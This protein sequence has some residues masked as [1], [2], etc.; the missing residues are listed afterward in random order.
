MQAI[1]FSV[2]NNPE[3]EKFIDRLG[4]FLSASFA[5]KRNENISK[6]DRTFKLIQ[7]ESWN[8]H[9]TYNTSSNYGATELR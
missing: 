4:G 9:D 8:L 7:T 2:P 5:A 6:N 1:K 3:T